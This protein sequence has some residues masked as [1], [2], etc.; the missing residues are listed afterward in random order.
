MY[1][2]DSTKRYRV[3]VTHPDGSPLIP[4]ALFCNA[5]L[6]EVAPNFVALQDN[7]GKERIY[8]G[9]LCIEIRE[10]E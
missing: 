2:F 8:T 9:S 4:C 7:N 1:Q 5:K 3:D 10:E 6:I